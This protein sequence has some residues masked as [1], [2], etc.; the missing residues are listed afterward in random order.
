MY[1]YII[2]SKKIKKSSFFYKK[3][4]TKTLKNSKTLNLRIFK[5]LVKSSR[6]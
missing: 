2:F 5:S 4:L 3:Y 6:H 1:N